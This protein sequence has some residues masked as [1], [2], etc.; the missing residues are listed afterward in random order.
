[1]KEN[2]P[3]KLQKIILYIE[4]QCFQKPYTEKMILQELSDPDSVILFADPGGAVFERSRLD[5][6]PCGYSIVK[7]LRFEKT[8]E[9]LRIAVLK[10]FRKQKIAE[11]M[12]DEIRR[13]AVKEGFRR[14]ILEVSEKNTAAVNLYRKFGFLEY[15]KR[16]QY[17]ADG[18]NA[19]LLKKTLT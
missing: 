4:N 9:I 1:M 8:V 5:F 14:I 12:M 18:S 10:N 2:Q 11:K 3:E 13:I 17:Y 6:D 19:L 16:K 7:I 15:H